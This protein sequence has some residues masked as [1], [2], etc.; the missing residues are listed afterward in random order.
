MYVYVHIYIHVF[1]HIIPAVDWSPF[2][3]CSNKCICIYKYLYLHIS[4]QK[5]HLYIVPIFIHTLHL[6][7]V[8]AT[9][10]SPSGSCSSR[11]CC[12][13]GISAS[14]V[15]TCLFNFWGCRATLCV[16]KLSK[17]SVSMCVRVLV[18]HVW[19]RKRKDL[20]AD[21]LCECL[22]RV[23]CMWG[24]ILYECEDNRIR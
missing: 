5:I 3:S 12:K 6:H 9:D 4:I 14:A 16:W 10:R 20:F 21:P 13:S 19:E 17:S 15:C 7:I 24:K 23:Q 1:I 22:S 8:P 2:S 18:E 11:C